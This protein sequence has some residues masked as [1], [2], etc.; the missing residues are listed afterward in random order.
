[1]QSSKSGKRGPIRRQL[2]RSG[3]RRWAQPHWKLWRQWETPSNSG[4]VFQAEP[5]EFAGALEKEGGARRVPQSF[6][7][8]HLLS[9]LPR[10]PDFFPPLPWAS[11]LKLWPKLVP[12]IAKVSTNSKIINYSGKVVERRDAVTNELNSCPSPLAADR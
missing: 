8:P 6:V 4:D 11:H 9:L 2:Q 7:L 3:E 5:R 10:P 12:N 1:M